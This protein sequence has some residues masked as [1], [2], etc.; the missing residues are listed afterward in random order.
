[1]PAMKEPEPRRHHYVPQCWLAGFTDTGEKDGQ[2]WVTDLVRRKQ[3][4]ASPNNAGH[5]RDFYRLSDEQL[6]PVMVEKAFANIE[7]EV[8]PILR[9]L[10]REQR[11]PGV[12]E[13]GALLP[14]IALQWARVPAFR[15][16]V[17]N[18]LD[19]VARE[20]L[21]AELKSEETWKRALKKARI[22][23]DAPGAAYESMMEFYRDG[24]FSL[25]VQTDWYVQQTFKAAEH[26]LPTL[27]GRSWRVAISPSGSFI[28][29][30]NP[31]ILDGPKNEMRGFKN[32]EII[33]Y[34][35]SRHV[36]LCS[37]LPPEPLPFVNRK[38]IAH[39][40]RLLLLR[41]EQVFSNVSDF[42][43]LD[44]NNKYQT[45]WTLFS[46]EKYL[47]AVASE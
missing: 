35:L 1:M 14:F 2:L 8:A 5:I 10:D 19:S 41:A 11:A 33:T 47:G 38:Y 24:R 29:S 15:P 7:A 34:V 22:A 37:T 39:L 43:W 9:I 44:E 6:D 12:E 20:T 4:Q 28:G 30:D 40:N 45:D 17:L 32:A 46:K 18:V 26:I 13:F 25:S 31:V 36:V 3:W 21:A 42:C 27:A 23:E 16:I